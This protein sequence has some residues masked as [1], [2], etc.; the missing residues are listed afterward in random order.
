ML[1]KP[2]L[3]EKVLTKE[4][5]QTRR[6]QLPGDEAIRDE[7]G[8]IIGVTRFDRRGR[9]R[10][11]YGVGL[12]YAVQPGRGKKALGYA[13]LGQI[14]DEQVKDISER[15]AIE[16]GVVIPEHKRGMVR[17]PHGGAPV[18]RTSYRAEFSLLW[19]SINAKRGY[20]WNDNPRVWVLT[21]AEAEEISC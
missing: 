2:D 16:E 21:F 17:L 14:R 9:R 10:L 12:V 13:T 4:K 18:A 5:T 7:T 1:F 15:D 3:A 11:L 8:R 19:D 20:G 6:V